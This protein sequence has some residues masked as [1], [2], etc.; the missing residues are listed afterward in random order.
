MSPNTILTTSF[1]NSIELS[2]KNETQFTFEASLKCKIIYKTK[3]IVINSENMNSCT[4]P[5]SVNHSESQEL[6]IIPTF[7]GIHSLSKPENFS[8]SIVSPFPGVLQNESFISEDGL[9]IIITFERSV[10]FMPLQDCHQM[11]TN[12]TIY[13]LNIYGLVNC[14][15]L[16]T[17]RYTIALNSPIIEDYF[18]ISIKKQIIQ[19][20]GQRIALN[21]SENIYLIVKKVVTRVRKYDNNPKIILRGPTLLPLCGPFTINAYFYSPKGLNGIVFKWSITTLPPRKGLISDQILEYINSNNRTS[22]LMSGQ[23]FPLDSIT[24]EFTI[25]AQLDEHNF[26]EASHQLFRSSDRMPVVTIFP[27]TPSL[28]N[29]LTSHLRSAII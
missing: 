4:I 1:M 16:T 13:G 11:L 18:H 2:F 10:N 28:P 12:S 26:I 23:M 8:L 21:N 9:N 7:D 27:T 15:W 5:G 3:Q 19:E 25:R 24:Y 22:L 6:L 14:F 17:T 29:Q 20:L